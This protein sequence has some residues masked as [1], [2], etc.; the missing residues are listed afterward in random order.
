MR[1]SYSNN[2]SIG[3]VKVIW[4]MLV[5]IFLGGFCVDVILGW[6]GKNIPFY[7]DAVMGFFTGQF[8]I[9]IAIVGSIL[10][11]FGIF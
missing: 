1:Y 2:A 10:K 11:W 4:I 3:C 8:A 5:N 6:F 7:G 9:P